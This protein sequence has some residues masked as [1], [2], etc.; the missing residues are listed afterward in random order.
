MML[1]ENI[2]PLSFGMLFGVALATL[3]IQANAA[4]F[5]LFGYLQVGYLAPMIIAM[6]LT[7][8]IAIIKPVTQV[9]N[10]APMSALKREQ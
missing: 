10:D 4:H 6:I 2:K 3:I 5:S 8:L 1:L 7:T 9:V